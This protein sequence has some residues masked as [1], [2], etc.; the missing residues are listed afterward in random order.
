MPPLSPFDQIAE[1]VELLL[2]RHAEL[3]RNNTLLAEQV[4]ALSLERDSL[5]SRLGAA[6]ARIDLLVDRLSERAPALETAAPASPDSPSPLP[7]KELP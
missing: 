1:R 5:R 4:A 3:Q 6:R 7:P 2:A